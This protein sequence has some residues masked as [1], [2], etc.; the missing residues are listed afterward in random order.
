MRGIVLDKITLNCGCGTDNALLE[1]S[2]KLLASM[3]GKK[4]VRTRAKTRIANWHLRKGLPI[5]AKVTLR[6]K[7]AQNML[8]RLLDAKE[9]T[10]KIS[11]IDSNGNVAFG[12]KECIDI[13]GVEYT[14]DIGIIGLECAVTLQR[15]GFRIKR[16]MRFT[17]HIPKRH[18]IS[19]DDAISFMKEKYGI[20]IDTGETE[21]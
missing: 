11:Q 14:P 9:K 13:P 2:F 16:R 12:I 3:T 5:G 15:P 1:K 7:D 4:P 20:T 19:K 18:T 6:G 21:E 8:V 10:L 17:K